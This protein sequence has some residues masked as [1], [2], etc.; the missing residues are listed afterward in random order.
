VRVYE[1]MVVSAWALKLLTLKIGCS[2]AYEEHGIP[3]ATG[4][5]LGYALA[6]LAGGIISAIRFFI[7]F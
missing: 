4:F 2:K 6:I 3:V 5:L 7:P 1:V